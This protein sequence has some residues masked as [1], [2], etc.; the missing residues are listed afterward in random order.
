M[1]FALVRQF[2]ALKA[3]FTLLHVEPIVLGDDGYPVDQ[4]TDCVD[5]VPPEKW[6]ETYTNTQ[7]TVAD[8]MNSQG[9]SPNIPIDSS[10]EP[11]RNNKGRMCRK[12]Y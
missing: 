2:H 9:L 5:P 7:D 10:S 4:W 12:G 6:L 8:V 11:P 1:T 3:S